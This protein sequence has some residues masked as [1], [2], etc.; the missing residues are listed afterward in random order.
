MNKKAGRL[1]EFGPFQL[2]VSEHRL[3]HREEIVPLTPKVF[4]TLLV[5]IEHSGHVIQKNELMMRLWP[6]S[7]VEE[8]SLT[9][10]ISLLR[11]ALSEAGEQQFIETVP[12]LGYRFVAPVKVLEVNGAGSEDDTP[13]PPD[14]PRNNALV[15]HSETRARGWSRNWA[16]L[17]GATLLL[18]TIAI[19]GIYLLRTKTRPSGFSSE[20]R[21]RSLAVLPLKS[22]ASNGSDEYL[23]LGMADA[24]IVKL[25]NFEQFNVRPTSSIIKYA[26]HDFDSRSVGRE[27]GVDTVL[28]GTIQHVDDRVRVTVMLLSVRDGK[29]L[30]S[31]KFDERR[32]DIFALQ[33]SISEKLASVLQLQLATGKQ[34]QLNKHFTENA[35]AYGDYAMGLYFWNKRSKD[36]LAK[37]IDYF[38]K[39]TDADHNYA[40]AYAMLAD[41]YCLTI[42]Y[43]SNITP[44]SDVIRKAEDAVVRAIQLDDTLAEAHAAMGLLKTYKSEFPAAEQSYRRAIELN[45][46]SAI[47]HYRYAFNLLSGLQND[48]AMREMQ[49]AQELDP[50]SLP[51]NTTLAGCL[52]YGGQ[53]DEAIKYSKLAL[54]VDPQ[55]GLARVN[56]G[57]A[58]EWKGMHNEAIAEYTKLSQQQGFRLY[59]KLGLAF[60]SARS[61]HQEQARR[62]LGEVKSEVTSE[63]AFFDLPL[64][65]A[66]AYGVLGE[67]DEAFVWLEKAVAS[68]HARR[69]DLRYSRQLN[70]LKEDL[71][72]EQI[73]RRHELTRSLASELSKQNL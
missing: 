42:F 73:L 53:Y 33:D 18:L 58:Y 34:A 32:T 65:I 5:L 14:E 72:Y 49:R 63:E 10:N 45:P 7:F 56:L 48:D 22:L 1:Y 54:E 50:I 21:V 27:L 12:K 13:R 44:S 28:D 8:S 61:G 46:N 6:D 37:A 15:S 70:T 35:E 26:G 68:F 31:G 30:W 23:G 11:K 62:L 16:M 52:L 20:E 38:Q 59:G 43:D 67:K 41:T 66:A 57:E 40:L 69:F 60:A 25:S 55:F 71:R 24:L 29:T 3:L 19:G 36:G 39:A 2:D 51:I 4:E 9:Q 64:Q 47:A 17:S